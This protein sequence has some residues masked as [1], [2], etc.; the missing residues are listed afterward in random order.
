MRA[1]ARTNVERALLSAVSASASILVRTLVASSASSRTKPFFR[2]SEGSRADRAR[3]TSSHTGYF[4]G[5][6]LLLQPRR[7]VRNHRNRLADLLRNDI[8]KNLLAV[9]RHIVDELLGR[10]C[11]NQRLRGPKL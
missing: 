5:K 4:S 11:R 1:T 7:K 8:Q 3:P 6:S 9:G 10:R 2:R